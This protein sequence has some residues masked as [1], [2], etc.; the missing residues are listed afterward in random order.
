MVQMENEINVIS[1]FVRKGD[2]IE[3]NKGLVIH[4]KANNSEYIEGAW[5]TA[6]HPNKPPISL[7]LSTNYYIYFGEALRKAAE[8]IATAYQTFPR[9]KTEPKDITGTIIAIFAQEPN[10]TIMQVEDEKTSLLYNIYGK[11][12][13][14][15]KIHRLFAAKA[16]VELD[17]S[18][19]RGKRRYYLVKDAKPLGENMTVETHIYGEYNDCFKRNYY[20]AE[21]DGEWEPVTIA[22]PDLEDKLPIDKPV[23][24]NLSLCKNSNNRVIYVM[25]ITTKGEIQI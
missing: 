16:K 22:D 21:F 23:L 14:S 7:Y 12:K 11:G 25:D 24:A 15:E 20:R 6:F 17:G 13:M 3:I 2:H 1:D 8:R 18:F 9:P 5:A 19:V 4:K 10:Y